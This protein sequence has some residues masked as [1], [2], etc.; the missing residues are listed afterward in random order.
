VVSLL[1]GRTPPAAALATAVYS[2]SSKAL[3]A[4]ATSNGI[5][6]RELSAW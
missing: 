5:V 2:I 6:Q 1:V 3:A 4:M